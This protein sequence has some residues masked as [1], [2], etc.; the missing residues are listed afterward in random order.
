M[1]VPEKKSLFLL[2]A[3]ASIYGP[4]YLG[5]NW[6]SHHYQVQ[7]HLYHPF[8]LQ[9]PR[10]SWFILFYFSAYLSFLPPLLCLDYGKQLGVAKSLI[11]SGFL[12]GIVFLL[13]PTG[14]GY[15]RTPEGLGI[16]LP[17][18]EIL[19]GQDSPV[20]LMPSFHV[21][22]ASIFIFPM[23]QFYTS[24]KM[25]AFFIIWLILISASIVLVH[26][27]HLIDIPTGLLL[28]WV[29]LKLNFKVK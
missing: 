26:Q 24:I 7:N 13:Y 17:L 9:I 25:K 19:W 12:G 8:E 22:M 3:T 10:L 15:E 29:S 14:L 2:L 27:H 20:T 18:Y 6:F 11:Y 23:I 1:R 16:F 4:T 21:A 28:A 5:V